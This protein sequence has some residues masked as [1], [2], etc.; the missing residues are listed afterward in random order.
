MVLLHIAHARLS[1][2]HF[3]KIANIYSILSSINIYPLLNT[4]LK[5]YYKCIFFRNDTAFRYSDYPVI[6]SNLLAASNLMLAVETLL[7]KGVITKRL[8]APLPGKVKVLEYCLDA[9]AQTSI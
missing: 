7:T 4:V 5:T 3:N 1:L 2:T 6:F 8:T 9:T